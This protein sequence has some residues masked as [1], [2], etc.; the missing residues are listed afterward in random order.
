MLN[1][2]ARLAIVTLL[3]VILG[4]GTHS[5]PTR[6]AQLVQSHCDADYATPTQPLASAGLGLTQ[7]EMDERYG[8]GLAAQEYRIYE[9]DGYDIRLNCSDLEVNIEQE[10]P[11]AD[12]DAAAQL[13]QSL[14]P[15]DAVRE[16]GW[17]FGSIMNTVTE[18]ELWHS[19]D[20]AERY[21][22]LENPRTGAIL[23]VYTY[24]HVT[25]GDERIIKVEMGA[26]TPDQ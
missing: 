16:G 7:A 25:V 12:P 18:I 2:Q 5:A 8:A 9:Q 17:H 11:Y 13:A 23:V 15:D 19:D 20:L 24:I 6:A 1:I 22:E 14:L 10:S 4:A 21:D 26:M 3:L